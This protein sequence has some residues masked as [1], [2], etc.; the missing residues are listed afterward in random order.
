MCLVLHKLAEN[1]HFFPL[2]LA[3]GSRSVPTRT[4]SCPWALPRRAYIAPLPSSI[5]LLHQLFSSLFLLRRA[6]RPLLRRLSPL[7]FSLPFSQL[8][9]SVPKTAPS[10]QSSESGET[11]G[12]RLDVLPTSPSS[13]MLRRGSRHRTSHRSRTLFLPAVIVFV[14]SMSYLYAVLGFERHIVVVSIPLY[15]LAVISSFPAKQQNL[16][17][18]RYLDSGQR[19]RRRFRAC[20]LISPPRASSRP[21]LRSCSRAAR[22]M[23]KACCVDHRSKKLT[24]NGS[25]D[26][27]IRETRTDIQT[28]WERATHKENSDMISGK[29]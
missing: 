10:P 29:T 12:S 13:R 1:A 14:T 6:T 23:L 4:N 18:E 25:T 20:D 8:P 15:L 5:L 22:N 11:H 2:Q 19:R 28:S 9:P 26:S 16:E 21:G 7:I 3:T 24:R 17:P 27:S